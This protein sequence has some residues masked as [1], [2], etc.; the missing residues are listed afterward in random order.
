MSDPTPP[1]HPVYEWR[2]AQPADFAVIGDP[3][4]HSLSPLMQTAALRS[5]GRSETYIAVHVLPREV[6]QA[7]DHLRSLGVKGVNVTLPHKFAAL[8]WSEASGGMQEDLAKRL[9]AA[10]TL[11]LPTGDAKNT[12][13]AGFAA[14]LRDLKPTRALVLGAGG[15]ARA[16]LLALANLGVQTRLFNRTPERAIGLIAELDLGRS[17]TFVDLP[18]PQG[19]DLIVNATSAFHGPDAGSGAGPGIDF[20]RAQT[21][22]LAYDLS[23]DRSKQLTPFLE[24]AARFGLRTQDGRAMLAY[25]GAH[26]LAWW[27]GPEAP[28]FEQLARPMLL[29]IQA[30]LP[31]D[32]PR[33]EPEKP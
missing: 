4:A 9:R 6:S 32:D 26:S 7:L 13:A 29:A 25:Q 17:T 22:A 5:L 19:C 8:E 3:I 33:T 31:P 27:L 14:S 21:S 2:E 24:I 1:G 12:D 20:S 23:Y 30:Q 16:I 11:N 10:N 15:S 18:D 28:P